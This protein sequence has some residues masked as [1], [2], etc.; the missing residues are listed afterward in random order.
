[1]VVLVLF[2]W[3][4]LKLR[5]FVAWD[6]YGWIEQSEYPSIL[7]LL[8]DVDPFSGTVLANN[9]RV[10]REPVVGFDELHAML[11]DELRVLVHELPDRLGARGA[12]G[13]KAFT[14]L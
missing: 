9:P 8:E 3:R 7:P 12:L 10:R 1:M 11:F 2:V 13:G 14:I 4:M 5:D 6:H